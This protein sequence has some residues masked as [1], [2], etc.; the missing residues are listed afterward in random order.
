[1]AKAGL[2]RKVLRSLQKSLYGAAQMLD[3]MVADTSLGL[4]SFAALSRAATRHER[5]PVRHTRVG[6]EIEKF[7]AESGLRGGK[8]LEIGGRGNP[9]RERFSQFDY[10]NL[11]IEETGEGVVLGDITDCPHLPDGSYDA[12]ISVDVFEH[13][14]RP[15]LASREICRLLKPGGVTYHSTLFSWRYHPCPI[16]YWRFSPDALRFL[17]SDI[18]HVASGFDDLERRRNIRGTGGTKIK[19]D[20]FGGWRENWRVYYCGRKPNAASDNKP[21]SQ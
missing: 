12:I 2:R 1:M 7:F 11:D 19:S 21:R 4:S 20:A 10:T 3:E 18:D 17:F 8:I 5:H 16:D 13:I 9:Y 6:N 15:W 14:N